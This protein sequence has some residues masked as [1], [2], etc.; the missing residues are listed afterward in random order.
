MVNRDHDRFAVFGCGVVARMLPYPRFCFS[1]PQGDALLASD[2]S[3]GHLDDAN[4]H[5]GMYHCLD[6]SFALARGTSG[7]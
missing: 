6:R 2:I 1:R 5:E 7:S 3:R 4:E